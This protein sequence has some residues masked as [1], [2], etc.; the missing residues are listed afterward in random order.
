MN[1]RQTVP[2]QSIRNIWH[3]KPMTRIHDNDIRKNIKK[4]RQ[5][6]RN[7]LKGVLAEQ[8]RDR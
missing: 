3:M 7:V 8:N 5:T 6:S 4:Q 1:K 2:G